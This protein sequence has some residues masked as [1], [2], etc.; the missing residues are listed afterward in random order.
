MMAA[1]VVLLHRV[2]LLSGAQIT[3]FWEASVSSTPSLA[4]RTHLLRVSYW[5]FSP[6]LLQPRV[7]AV[8]KAVLYWV[9]QYRAWSHERDAIFR[10]CVFFADVH[11][12]CFP[13]II[14][15]S[16]MQAMYSV[17]NLI[18]WFYWIYQKDTSLRFFFLMM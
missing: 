2:P 18:V 17:T 10:V 4:S 12:V 1:E 3:F 11:P 7:P 14:C 6:A 13:W 8:L 5:V 15:F 9:G 16:I